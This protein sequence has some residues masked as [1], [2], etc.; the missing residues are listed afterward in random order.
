MFQITIR[1]N[2]AAADA[3]NR[4]SDER[5]NLTGRGEIDQVLHVGR[6]FFSRIDIVASPQSSVRIGRDSVMDA[7]TVRHIKF[8][9]AIA[10]R[11]HR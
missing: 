2:D 9:A 6:V 7:E 11:S 10:G 3:L 4:F 8:P 1:K 5:S